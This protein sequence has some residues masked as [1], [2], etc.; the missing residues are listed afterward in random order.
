MNYGRSWGVYD[1]NSYELLGVTLVQPPNAWKLSY[2]HMFKAGSLKSPLKYGV[3][4]TI[5]NLA[6]VE[7]LDRAREK[8]MGKNVHYR[9][10][11]LGVLPSKQKNNFGFNFNPTLTD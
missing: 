4:P 3:V 10:H 11:S 2:W 9:L 7:V 6:F 1:K 8:H 5:R